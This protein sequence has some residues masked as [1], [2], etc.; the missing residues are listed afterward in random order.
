MFTKSRN[1]EKAARAGKPIM[2]PRKPQDL[3]PYGVEE[4]VK[5]LALWAEITR[6]TCL[7]GHTGFH[8]GNFQKAGCSFNCSF[9]DASRKAGGHHTNVPPRVYR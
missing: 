5:L 2:W 4:S 9:Q 7:L 8:G 3:L 1:A 6:Y